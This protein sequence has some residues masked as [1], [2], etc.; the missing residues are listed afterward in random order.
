MKQVTD[1]QKLFF[2]SQLEICQNKLERFFQGSRPSQ[3]GVYVYPPCLTPKC[4][5][6]LN[7]FA[8]DKRSSLFLHKK[9]FIALT[10][11]WNGRKQFGINCCDNYQLAIFTGATTISKTTL[12]IMTLS[13]TALRIWCCNAE[14]HILSV[15]LFVIM[16]WH[17][18]LRDSAGNTNWRGRLSTVGLLAP[19]SLVLLLCINKTFLPFKQN[20]LT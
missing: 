13:I 18:A 20:E 3:V 11:S 16:P 15:M 5:T 12:G 10:T 2:S 9:S 8:R 6:W 1:T 14:C 19:T 7:F 4:L 17:S